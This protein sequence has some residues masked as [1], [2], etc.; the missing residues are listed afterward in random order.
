MP[1]VNALPLVWPSLVQDESWGVQ[2]EFRPPSQLPALM[3]A[4]EVEAILVSSVEALRMPNA[5]VAAGMSISSLRRVTSVRLV[6]KVPLEE[7]KTLALDENSMT[8]NLLAQVLLRESADLRPIA[9]PRKAD[10]KSML[11]E[12][13]ACVVIGDVG[14]KDT[15]APLRTI[16]LGAW[17]EYMFRLPFVWALWVGGA[18]LSPSLVAKL[19]WAKEQGIEHLSEAAKVGADRTGL[20]VSRVT[21]YLS[22]NVN[23]DL[24]DDHLRGLTLFGE[25]LQRH[26]FET[27]IHMPE[28]VD[29]AKC[30]MAQ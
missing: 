8:S 21:E 5:R 20:S 30:C 25:L 19:Q 12:F 18:D 22:N 28:V 4:G 15:P 26:G 16:D 14:M 23:Y 11:A 9:E 13:D 3:S 2:V 1:F 29:S 24:T 6:S 7:I 27:S 10:V 17:W